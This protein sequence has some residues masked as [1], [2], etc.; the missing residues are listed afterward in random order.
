MKRIFNG[1]N[2]CLFTVDKYDRL[3]LEKSNDCKASNI[4]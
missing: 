1:D 2:S 3:L 4:S